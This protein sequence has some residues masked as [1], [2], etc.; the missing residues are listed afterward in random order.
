MATRNGTPGESD[1]SLRLYPGPATRVNWDYTCGHGTTVFPSVSCSAAKARTRGEHRVRPQHRGPPGS[2][3]LRRAPHGHR[4]QRRVGAERR[5]HG[6]AGRGELP[7]RSDTRSCP[8][9]GAPRRPPLPDVFFNA[10]HGAG[11]EDGQ[12]QGFLEPLHRPYTGAGLLAMAAALD[13]WITKRIWESEGLPVVPYRGLTEEGWRRAPDG[14]LR[15]LEALG[16]PLFVKPAN[17]GSS[18]GIEKMKRCGGPGRGPGPGLRLRPAGAGGA[19]RARPGAGSGRAGRGRPLRQHAGRDPGGRR[20]LRL[21]GQVHGRQEPGP[22]PG[23]TARGHGQPDRPPRRAAFRALDAY[24]MARVDFFLDRE[25]GRLF[26]NEINL[27]PGFTSISMYPKLWRPAASPTRELLTRLID[28]AL[29]PAPGEDRQDPL[30]P[31]RQ[32]V[33]QRLKPAACCP[34]QAIL[35]A[36]GSGP[37]M[38]F[39]EPYRIADSG[40]SWPYRQ[41][42]RQPQYLRLPGRRLVTEELPQGGVAGVPAGQPGP[43]SPEAPTWIWPPRR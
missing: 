26:L 6:P 12:I 11:G 20:I 31:E 22:H 2:G 43:T 29:R 8:W 7:E 33:V 9:S 21:Q 19:G 15:G 25:T 4:P 10:I 32:P 34:N 5:S 42:H 18:I 28:L 14:V 1:L 16:L 36:M 17:L 13:K 23:R 37:W 30:L 27:I 24:G 39:G 35:E 40:Q 3:A 38:P 41:Q